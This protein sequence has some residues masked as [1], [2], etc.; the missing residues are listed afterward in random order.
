MGRTDGFGADLLP[1]CWVIQRAIDVLRDRFAIVQIGSGTPLFQF[2]HIDLDLAGKTSVA[3]LLDV[4]AGA[5]GFLGYVSYIV[6][7]AES[8]DKPAMLVWSH[9]GMNRGHQY[10]R[11]I[12]PKKILGKPSS[13]FVID[14]WT[15]AD[16][17]KE[18]DAFLR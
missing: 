9:K 3:G 5:S 12:T 2:R 14:D 17:D 7:L 4:A 6:P 1:D 18:F 10:I 15:L 8:L 16:I 13:K 11:Q